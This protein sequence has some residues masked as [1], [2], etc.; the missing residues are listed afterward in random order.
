VRLRKRIEIKSATELLE[1]DEVGGWPVRHV[2]EKLIGFPSGNK[3]IKDIQT[4]I[5]HGTP[6]TR[7]VPPLTCVGELTSNPHT[8]QKW[9][10]VP[11][12]WPNGCVQVTLISVKEE[13]S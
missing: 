9:V 1:G 7:E 13:A 10:H 2:G 6:V 8:E 3:D 11:Y 4:L 5:D 12:E